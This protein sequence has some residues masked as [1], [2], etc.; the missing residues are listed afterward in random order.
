MENNEARIRPN[1]QN[2]RLIEGHDLWPTR[3]IG[4]VLSSWISDIYGPVIDRSLSL[5]ILFSNTNAFF[6][7]IFHHSMMDVWAWGMSSFKVEI[8]TKWRIYSLTPW[9]DKIFRMSFLGCFFLCTRK[10]NKCLWLRGQSVL[11]DYCSQIFTPLPF[12]SS[13]LPLE[14]YISSFCFCFKLSVRLN[15]A[16]SIWVAMLSGRLKH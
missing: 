13:P 16:K 2:Q 6:W 14:K 11:I 1:G 3:G 10:G 9:L 15:L 7:W 4:S 8:I 12:L 5:I